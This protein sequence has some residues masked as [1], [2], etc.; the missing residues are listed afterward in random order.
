MRLELL[1]CGAMWTVADAFSVL[2]LS[3]FDVVGDVHRSGCLA[4]ERECVFRSDASRECCCGEESKERETRTNLSHDGGKSQQQAS[5][6]QRLTMP[7]SQTAVSSREKT[8]AQALRS[9]VA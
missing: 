1:A 8:H 9:H 6:S 2:S 5:L 7:M 4:N 3:H